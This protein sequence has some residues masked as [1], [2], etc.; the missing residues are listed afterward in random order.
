MHTQP[1]A[2]ECC[3][4]FLLFQ[5]CFFPNTH[6]K[7][8]NT[9]ANG[10]KTHK[11]KAKKLY[12]SVCSLEYNTGLHTCIYIYIHNISIWRP[13]KSDR[14]FQY[15]HS[16]NVRMLFCILCMPCKNYTNHVTTTSKYHITQNSVFILLNLLTR[17]RNNEEKKQQNITTTTT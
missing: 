7:T 10:K 12:I 14:H 4:F 9:D 8:E 6:N 5:L 13:Y 3:A 15:N 17:S 16:Q 11:T 1:H 2:L